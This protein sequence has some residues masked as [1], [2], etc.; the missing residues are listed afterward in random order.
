LIVRRFCSESSGG[1]RELR[2]VPTRRSSDLRHGARAALMGL[3]CNVCPVRHR[4]AC[5]VLSDDEREDLARAGRSR[6]LR[7][8]ELLFAAGDEDRKSTRLN[9]SHVKISYVVFCWTKKAL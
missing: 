4:A 3:N 5:S 9:S 6:T 1:Q 2:S 7:R 8:G